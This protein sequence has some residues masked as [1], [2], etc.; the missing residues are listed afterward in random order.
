[1]NADIVASGFGLIE[2]PLW[3]PG[4]GVIFADADKG[5]AYLLDRAGNVSTV[6]EHRRGIG[7]MVWH[8]KGGLV[9]SGRNIAY[10]GPATEGT[11]V[12]LDRDAASG[13]VGFNDM[14]TDRKGRIYAG[15][16]G[17]LPT[18]TELSGIGGAGKSAPLLLIDLDG[19]VR[20]VHPEVKLTNGMGFNPDGTILYHADSG[21]RTV[22]A[23]DVAS[24]GGL[25]RRRPFAMT[26]GGLP[27]GLAVAADGTVW[28]AVAHAGVV[29]VFSAEG[30]LDRSIE[31][32]IPMVTSLCF[33]GEDM[34]DV[35]VTSGSDG[36]RR[37]DAGTIF[38]IR[39]E[40]PGLPA[41]PARVPLPGSR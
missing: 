17:F 6:F 38:R 22:Y 26:A 33:G 15:A 24:D 27:D 9:V 13:M 19:S 28:V 18:E 21:D 23:Y 20:Q 11:A 2:G 25:S 1:V 14:T 34:R 37:D 39:S 5:G 31:F 8:E 4:Q 12:L 10:K 36:S 32:P 29:K 30:D 41:A 3:R 35:Y 40:V 7:G 16:L